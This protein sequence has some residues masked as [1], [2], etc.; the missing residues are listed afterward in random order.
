[1]DSAFPT[2]ILYEYC[3]YLKAR[4]FDG[5]HSNGLYAEDTAIAYQSSQPALVTNRLQM[6]AN[7]MANCFVES[8]VAVNMDKI[9]GT[10]ERGQTEITSRMK[11][12]YGQTSNT[13]EKGG[14]ILAK[15]HSLIVLSKRRCTFATGSCSRI[16]SRG[17]SPR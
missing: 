14:E 7:Q 3:E 15:H 1:M 8:Q 13:M 17:E 9:R 16:W 4:L 10:D 2:A 6:H 5:R 11:R 12:Y